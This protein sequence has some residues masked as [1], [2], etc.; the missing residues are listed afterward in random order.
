MLC[1]KIDVPIWVKHPRD[2]YIKLRRNSMPLLRSRLFI[3]SSRLWRLGTWPRRIR[4]S[5]IGRKGRW[6]FG[7]EDWKI[8]GTLA[9]STL[10]YSVC[11]WP[12]RSGLSSISS[13]K[14]TV[15]PPVISR[16]IPWAHCSKSWWRRK[17]SNQSHFF[18]M[19]SGWC[20]QPPSMKLSS[21]KTRPN[22]VGSISNNS[23]N[24][25]TKI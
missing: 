1:T 14:M 17:S 25:L 9:I 3:R 4:S 15:F 24:N 22:S 12:R 5:S 18:L 6:V 20:C 23:W 10:S 7:I 21:N 13:P 8:W 2:S 19:C 16:H 11:S